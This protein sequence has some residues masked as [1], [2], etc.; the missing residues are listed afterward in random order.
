MEWLYRPDPEYEV[1]NIYWLISV[2]TGNKKGDGKPDPS[3][4][5]WAQPVGALKDILKNVFNLKGALV[6]CTYR[7][8]NGLK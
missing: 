4:K 1:P 3:I 2:F 5:S 8:S 7:L 6:F